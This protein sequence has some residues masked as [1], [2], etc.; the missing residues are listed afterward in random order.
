MARLH[1]P[2]DVLGVFVKA[3]EPGRVKTRLGRII[4]ARRAATLYRRMGLRVVERCLD[5]HRYRTMVWFAPVE[6]DA[7]VR[8]WLGQLGIDGF[9]GQAPGGLGARLLG[10]FAY[11]FANGAHRVVIIGS[12]CPGVD[13]ALIRRAFSALEESDL[14]IG[15][16]QDGGFYLLGLTRRAPGL[17]RRI[18]W[19][20]AAVFRQVMR[21][22]SVLG[23]TV[24]V[25]RTLRDVDTVE[26]AQAA[27]LLNSPPI[28]SNGF[29]H[30]YRRGA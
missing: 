18:E 3:P 2:A 4:G 1:S 12:D 30:A 23:R 20:T 22:A 24:A 19:S 11:H 10:A 7:A 29:R 27:G 21:N 8:G 13:A 14:V 16:A 25:L 5:P 26:D 28:S 6:S 9:L 15:P 17:F